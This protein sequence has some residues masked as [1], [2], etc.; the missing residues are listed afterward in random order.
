M[1]EDIFASIGTIL[2][3]ESTVLANVWRVVT[4]RKNWSKIVGSELGDCSLPLSLKGGRLVVLVSDP[5]WNTQLQF[6]KHKIL[7]DSQRLL[8]GNYVKEIHFRIR[9]FKKKR[10]R[11]K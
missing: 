2:S 1:K 3:K 8:N 4:L 10:S 11:V 9:E 7:K 5:A 6:I